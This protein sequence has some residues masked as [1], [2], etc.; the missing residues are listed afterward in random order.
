MAVIR[1]S[2]E[3]NLS[4]AIANYNNYT[5]VK[6]N[7][8]MPELKEDEWSK[9]INNI[10]IISF[11]QGLNIGGKVYNGYSIINNTKNNEYVSEDSIYLADN[12]DNGNYY[13]ITDASIKN[14]DE[15]NQGKFIGVLNTDF[16]RRTY[17]EN[18]I[19]KYFFPKKQLASYTSII[20][21]SNIDTVTDGNLYKYVQNKGYEIAKNYYTALGRERYSMYKTNNNIETIGNTY[22]T[23]KYKVKYD[24]NGG[25]GTV[26]DQEKVEGQSLTL[27]GSKPTK[28]KY[29]F[30]G[31]SK[32]KN[33]KEPTYQPSGIYN[34]NKEI[35]LYAVW[36]E[37][38]SIPRGVKYSFNISGSNSKIESEWQTTIR[39][40][41]GDIVNYAFEDVDTSNDVNKHIKITKNNLL[42][43]EWE[44]N[45]DER[46][47]Y[48]FKAS[49]TANYYFDIKV[50]CANTAKSYF[51]GTFKINS[52]YNENTGD[53][54]EPV[55]NNN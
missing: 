43:T 36:W 14:D 48:T 13:K 6:A 35:T 18:G 12:A 49:E 8:Q 27:S 34:E 50:S 32:D 20:N 33:A 19:A 5:D 10:S 2:I 16:E 21:Q 30:K 31:W 37:N 53:W 9:I 25:N 3:K 7:F 39:L 23:K 54:Y 47:T 52:I 15:A 1:Y 29:T 38:R 40:N 46:E 28:S 11:L 51:S 4:I 22:G 24:L 55:I 42:I 17:T 45:F 26:T 44:S 41:K